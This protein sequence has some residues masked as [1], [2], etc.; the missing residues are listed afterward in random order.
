MGN[1][2][3]Y[4]KGH[5][6]ISKVLCRPSSPQRSE[7]QSVRRS[8]VGRQLG[9]SLPAQ[10]AGSVCVSGPSQQA[11]RPDIPQPWSTKKG[12]IERKKKKKEKGSMA[13]LCLQNQGQNPDLSV[14]PPDVWSLPPKMIISIVL[15][16][17][18]HFSLNKLY[19]INLSCILARLLLSKVL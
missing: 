13:N 18:T 19:T 7:E 12:S 17:S 1:L 3:F 8:H 6:D 5:L 4:A 16:P 14:Q 11:Q 10:R 2:Y 9:L 15:S